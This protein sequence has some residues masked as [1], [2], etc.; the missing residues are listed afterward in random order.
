[1][2]VAT[3]NPDASSATWTEQ[4]GW[5]QR[6]EET[7]NWSYQAGHG[8]SREV[9]SQGT[10][11]HTWSVSPGGPWAAAVVSFKA[12]PPPQLS[13]GTRTPSMLKVETFDDFRGAIGLGAMPDWTPTVP[14]LG[15]VSAPS[16]W[17]RVRARPR[18]RL[19]RS[20]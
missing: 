19:S 5:T 12:A 17:I 10:Y 1:V 8:V 7:D 11:S 14:L 3:A 2:A 15:R 16:V 9:T 13:S 18:S 6:V 20:T 4:A